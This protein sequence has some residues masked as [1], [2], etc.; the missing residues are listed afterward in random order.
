MNKASI[1][2]AG[3]QLIKSIQE[4]QGTD[5]L[6]ECLAGLLAH[7]EKESGKDIHVIPRENFRRNY[8]FDIIPAPREDQ[9][10]QLR[11][12]DEA[13]PAFL[14]L[15]TS[16]TSILDHLPENLYSDP[17]NSMELVDENGNQRQPED[18]EKYRKEKQERLES[19]HRFF[20]P[21]EIAYNQLRIHRELN[22]VK[23][24][25]NYDELLSCFWGK[26]KPQNERWKRFIR[27]LHLTPGIIGDPDKTKAL[28]EYV[29]DKPVSLHFWTEDYYTIEK[30]EQETLSEQKPVLGFNLRL[31][32]L[33]YDYQEKCTLTIRQISTE[34][35]FRYFDENSDDRKLLEEILKYY[36]PLNIDVVLDFSIKQEPPTDAGAAIPV[37]G[38]SSKL[39]LHQGKT[40]SK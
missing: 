4:G 14:T 5:I 39:G 20:R 24:L 10:D 9:F 23:N 31:G 28:L 33:V 34:Q 21:L 40:P 12:F 18:L 26:Y 22:E 15:Y 30:E 8:K 36:F 37:L 17:D 19:A 6:F 2:S 11:F 38:Y 1:I 27:T 16:R 29:L 25:E 7:N 32:N 35:F 3:E 13:Y